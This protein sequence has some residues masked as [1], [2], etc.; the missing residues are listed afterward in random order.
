MELEPRTDSSPNPFAPSP[1]KFDADALTRAL[2]IA[3]AALVVASASTF[4][5]QH[6]DSGNDLTRY[7][8]LVS[9]ALLLAAAAYF[10]GLTIREG[11]SARTFLGLVLATIPISFAVLGGLVY[12][13]FHLESL[14]VLP[15]YASWIAPT[16]LSALLAVAGTLVVLVPLAV[17]SFVALARK[18]AKALTL[19]FMAS[20]LLVI[21]PLRSPI[22]VAAIAGLALALLLQF[23]LARFSR[24]PR[25]DNLEGKVARAILFVP[26]LIMIGRVFHLYQ[27]VYQTS[28]PFFGALTLVGASLIWIALGSTESTGKRDLGA[29]TAAFLALAG[30]GMTW[31]DIIQWNVHSAAMAVLML[32]LPAAGFLLIASFRGA[33]SRDALNA[34]GVILGL[35]TAVIASLLDL[36]SM[37]AFSCVV[38]GI[39]VAVWGAALR[40]RVQLVG[41]ALVALFG[42]VAQVWLAVHA[43]NILRWASLSVAGILL[44]VG[45]AYIERNRP[46]LAQLWARL[47]PRPLQ[48]F[49]P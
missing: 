29:W 48:T 4:M 32:G 26:P 28:T 22:A 14:A 19:L 11:R 27:D 18:E 5:L 1:L 16:K 24:T 31:P 37:A 2:R 10:V 41:G 3:G 39:L 12:S 30:W 35:M 36:D 23:E 44:I 38:L 45:S 7:A 20:N 42:L 9:Q 34:L 21:V 33:H 6:W 17:V 47:S 8:M 40:Q 15:H 25:L 13:Q 46:R 43:D 49:E